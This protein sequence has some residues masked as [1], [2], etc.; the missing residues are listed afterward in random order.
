MIRIIK[1]AKYFAVIDPQDAAL[2]HVT[3]GADH[4]LY[5]QPCHVGYLLPR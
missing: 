1:S 2:M 3:H 4:C 5:T